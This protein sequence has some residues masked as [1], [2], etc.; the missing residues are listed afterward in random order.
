M[1]M[2]WQ[3]ATTYLQRGTWPIRR[4]AY[5][6]R[7]R[8]PVAR[9]WNRYANGL[10]LIGRRL[11]VEEWAEEDLYEHTSSAS[12]FD[13]PLGNMTTYCYDGGRRRCAPKLLSLG[14]L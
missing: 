14:L 11:V 10:A 3:V 12:N 4:K 6:E 13:E 9:S 1:I 2:Y 5:N 7:V 8:T